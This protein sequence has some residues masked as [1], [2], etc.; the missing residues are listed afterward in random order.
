M[1]VLVVTDPNTDVGKVVEEGG[2]GYWCESNDVNQFIKLMRKM[3]DCDRKSMGERAYQ[4][5]ND[6]YTSEKVYEIIIKHIEEKR[7]FNE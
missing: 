7:N 1:P 5:L 2:F 6:N 4:Y 3:I